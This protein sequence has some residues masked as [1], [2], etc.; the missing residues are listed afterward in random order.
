MSDMKKLIEIITDEDFKE[1]EEVLSKAR[2]GHVV[3][4]IRQVAKA[5]DGKINYV[6]IQ[7]S[8]AECRTMLQI[9]GDF[10]YI[11][12]YNINRTDVRKI[13]TMWNT[14]VQRGT[15][16]FLQKQENDYVLTIDIVKDEAEKGYAYTISAIQPVF[17]SSDGDT[18]LMLVFQLKDIWYS[19]DAVSI[20]DIEYEI[21]QREESQNDVYKVTIC[22]DED[23]QEREESETPEETADFISTDK[24]TNV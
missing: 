15:N 3:G 13:K 6:D 20:Y 19:K 24:Y 11:T 21:S 1:F 7:R 12:M 22:E 2:E 4:T 23:E 16:R 5:A 18:D 10:I 14:V 8:V 17:A 9:N